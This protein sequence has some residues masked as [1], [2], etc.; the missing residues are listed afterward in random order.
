VIEKMALCH[1]S[2]FPVMNKRLSNE[3]FRVYVLA[4]ESR[5]MVKVRKANCVRHTIAF[6]QMGYAGAPDW[7]TLHLFPLL[8]P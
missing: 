8:K 5:G 1:L 6:A 7:N 4:S 3:H 2:R